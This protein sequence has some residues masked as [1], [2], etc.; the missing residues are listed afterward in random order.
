MIFVARKK[1]MFA[2]NYVMQ[3]MYKEFPSHDIIMLCKFLYNEDVLGI[4]IMLWKNILDE[5][6]L[7][8]F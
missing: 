6:L 4:K 5:G 2:K 1:T 3:V 8:Y 7:H